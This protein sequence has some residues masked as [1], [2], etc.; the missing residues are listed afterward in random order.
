[1][2]PNLLMT[3]SDWNPQF[4]RE[5]KGRLK[6]RNIVITI[7][8]SLLVQSVILLYLWAALPSELTSYSRYCVGKD[9]Y[10]W[11][12][13]VLD[14]L[15]NV[16]INWQ[17][18]WFDLF[19]TLSWLMPFVV[20]V[21]GVYMLIG[22][23]AKEERR[24]TL[25]FIRLSPQP[26]RS[27]LMGKLLGVP[28]IPLLAVMLAVPLHS[29]AA[30]N[31]GI[32]LAEFASIYLVTVAACCFLYTAA[33]FYAFLGGS[34]GWLG[35]I[36]V[37]FSYTIFFQIWQSSRSVEPDRYLYLGQWYTIWIGYRL[38]WF[39]TFVVVTFAIATFW[40]WQSINRRFRN[41]SQVLLSKRQSYLMTLSFELFI[42][43]FVF[44]DY[45]EW[46]IRNAFFDLTGLMVVNLFWFVL[47]I[48]ALTPHRQTLLDWARYRRDGE[49]KTQRKRWQR[50][51]VRD[52]VWGD[53]S[54]AMVAISL[55]LLIPVLLFMPWVATW[56]G[57]NP[58]IAG[59]LSLIFSTSFLLI[60][61]AIAQ[62]ILFSKSRKRALFAAGTVGAIIFLPLISMGLLGVD[63]SSET[64]LLWLFSAMPIAALEYASFTTIA[65][66]FL[67]HLSVLTLLVGRQTYL[68]R[69][70]G[71]SELKTL[72]AHR[73]A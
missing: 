10:N 25:N 52:L 1:M 73:T 47:I 17:L 26:S 21:A 20:L 56:N 57:D 12:K 6:P 63:P 3:F 18:W 68:L 4:F 50:T 62:L 14:A 30:I 39:V 42:F 53:K 13:C 72:M 23:L 41:P 71:E 24:G 70:A 59:F 49:S 44:R 60:C 40:L 46:S 45:P 66:G 34:H 8:S 5:V 15:G 64:V 31:A 61:A 7:A 33:V 38:E 69:R 11:N 28:L 55:N 22:D 37:W 43:G 19:Q 54:P 32:P 27:I 9:E 58:R 65:I 48:T 35:A 67:A 36:A 29:W 2:I 16:Q 51:L